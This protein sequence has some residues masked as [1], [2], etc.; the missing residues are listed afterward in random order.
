MTSTTFAVVRRAKAPVFTLSEIRD[1][2]ALSS[3]RDDDMVGMKAA[4][5]EKLADVHAKLAELDRIRNTCA[6]CSAP[7]SG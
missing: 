6:S 4:A 3:H 7:L 5:T 2:L 1:L